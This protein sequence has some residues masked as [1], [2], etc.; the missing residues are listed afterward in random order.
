MKTRVSVGEFTVEVSHLDRRNLDQ[1]A[2]RDGIVLIVDSSSDPDTLSEI[3][4]SGPKLRTE[5][6]VHWAD[7]AVAPPF[8][9]MLVPE[10]SIIFVGGG[11]VS[12]VVDLVAGE[13]LD[14][15]HVFLFWAFERR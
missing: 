7:N 14:E 9:V 10:T 8:Q 6:V 15:K 5:V 3:V 12:A 1:S 4:V 11:S 13:V 2:R